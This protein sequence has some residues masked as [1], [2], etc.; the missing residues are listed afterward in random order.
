MAVSSNS[1]PVFVIF[2]D[3]QTNS[4]LTPVSDGVQ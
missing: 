3:R 1:G 2:Q 4:F